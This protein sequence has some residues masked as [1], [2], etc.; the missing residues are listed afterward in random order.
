MFFQLECSSAFNPVASF[1]DE[2][3]YK[4]VSA[5]ELDCE[6]EIEIGREL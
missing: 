1:R 2:I 6:T 4:Y 3:K 5:G